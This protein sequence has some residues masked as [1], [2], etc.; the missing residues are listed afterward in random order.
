MMSLP[1]EDR[2]QGAVRHFATIRPF[3]A[4]YMIKKVGSRVLQLVFK[5][6]T[7]T[8][9][10]AITTCLRENW[11]EIVRAPEALRLIGTVSKHSPLPQI[12]EDCFLLQGTLKG[13]KVLH[14]YADRDPQAMEGIKAKFYALREAASSNDMKAQEQL[15]N[16]AMKAA[17]KSYFYW[18]ISKLVI[19]LALGSMFA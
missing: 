12:Q 8:E 4:N 19:R 2:S 14:E 10:T 6:A 16:L 3:L 15:H 5:W 13:A 7:E 9:R 17:S 1:R 11:N 18:P